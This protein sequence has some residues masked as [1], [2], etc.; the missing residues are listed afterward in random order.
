[1][2]RYN[3]TY[4]HGT[5]TFELDYYIP[6]KEECRFLILKVVE[7][8]TRDYLSL[9][10]SDLSSDINKWE[11]AA[12]LI[13]DPEYRILWGDVD[14]SLEDL[15]NIVDIDTNWFREKITRCFK[16]RHGTQ[17]KE[18]NRNYRRRNS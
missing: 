7:Q 6:D 18:Y 15:L 3:R 16:E 1:M 17:E 9:F 8:A 5:A 13:F 12:G 4:Q 14:L 10:G 11:S 2:D